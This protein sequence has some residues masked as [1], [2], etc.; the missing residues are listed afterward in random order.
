VER[1]TYGARI[2]GQHEGLTVKIAYLC[3]SPIPSNIASSIQIMKMCGALA[4]DHEVMLFCPTATGDCRP[5]DIYRFY[6]VQPTFSIVRLP[7]RGS[8]I[9]RMIHP[10]QLLRW[11]IA[12][13]R[14]D[15]VYARCNTWEHYHLHKIKRP[16]IFEAHLLRQGRAIDKLFLHP[17]LRG[18]VVIS[19]ALRKDYASTHDLDDVKVLVEHDGADPISTHSP[20]K[21]PG[22]NAVK[23]GYVGN[24]Y[25]GKGVEVLIP[26]ARRC[27]HVDFH[28]FGGT[29]DEVAT[30]RHSNGAA[31]IPNLWFHGSLPPADTD[32]ARLAC[33][34]LIAPYQTVVRGAGD[35][36]D[37]GRWM[38]PLKIFEYMAAGKAIIASDLPTLRE[39]LH[40]HENAFLVPPHDLEAW[41]G[42]VCALAADAAE[43]QRLGAR[44]NESFVEH[45]SWRARVRRIMDAFASPGAQ[46]N[47]AGNAPVT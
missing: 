43:R 18:L 30:W 27:P 37:L 14:F 41:T 39:V 4:R 45:Y 29:E 31:Q 44:A 5:A 13:G 34:L 15:L 26:L 24:L 10:A 7:R 22:A 21:L 9:S 17:W 28:I 35:R 33:D 8:G 42:A 1:V 32:A 20:A 16:M 6:G 47:A 11:Q 46:A 38:S 40:H 25:R 3:H 36:G 19:E 12:L 2:D 23:C